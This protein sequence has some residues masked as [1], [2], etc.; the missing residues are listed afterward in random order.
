MLL[1]VREIGQFITLQVIPLA[2]A[3]SIQK[4]DWN[5][6]NI[7]LLIL[8]I[9]LSLLL[10]EPFWIFRVRDQ[11]SVSKKW[12]LLYSFISFFYLSFMNIVSLYAYF[13]QGLGS[14]QFEVTQKSPESAQVYIQQ[15]QNLVE[16]S[17]EINAGLPKLKPTKIPTIVADSSH[18]IPNIALTNTES[19]YLALKIL[20]IDIVELPLYVENMAKVEERLNNLPPKKNRDGQI[21][22]TP[23]LLMRICDA[24]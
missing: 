5:W 14:H 16:N 15:P 22:I 2:M 9:N 12:F 11:E 6:S 21:I 1:P 10:I 20:N 7:W 23:V 17:W 4:N 18:K 8:I 13:R 3:I 19:I 24:L